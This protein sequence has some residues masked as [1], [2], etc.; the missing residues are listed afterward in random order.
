MSWR[1]RDTTAPDESKY[2][3]RTP[4]LV[5]D[6]YYHS[7]FAY[8]PVNESDYT[9]LFFQAGNRNLTG[10][11]ALMGSLY[12]DPA[13]PLIDKQSGISQGYL[14]YRYPTSVGGV[15]LRIRVKG[16]AFWDRFGYLEKYDTYIFGRTHQMG[17]QVKIDADVGK[18]T[19]SALHGVGA[20]LEAI[21]ANQGLSLLNYL[22]LGAA[23]DKT[24]EVGFYYLRTWTQDKRQLK[25]LTDASLRNYGI[26]ARVDTHGFG[27]I[28]LAGSILDADQA[29]YLSP[30]IEVLH[31]FGG[32]G[33]TENYLGTDKSDN[34]TGTI[35]SFGFQYDLSARKL[36]QALAPERPVPAHGDIQLSAFGLYS[37]VLSK[38]YDS[39][40]AINKN[41]RKYFKWGTELTVWALAWLGAS[42]RYDRVVMDVD[43]DA[44][45]FRIISPRVSI[46]TDWLEGGQIFLQWSRYSYGDRVRLRPG[47]V[48]LETIPD[49]NVVKIQAQFAF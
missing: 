2:D 37:Y 49:D 39:D 36:L 13:R 20:H 48:A 10:T 31:S 46:R 1:R 34:G 27:R 7:G 40:P 15:P 14:T 4:W 22:R 30:S 45:A 29:T 19:L 3:L 41:E 26:D 44:N 47:Q 16:G 25:E 9:E 21:D 28:Y 8:T 17:E 38:Q 5:D 6:D 33:I 11:V 23:W 12:S 24:V 35:K 43:D 18:L 42:V 32:R